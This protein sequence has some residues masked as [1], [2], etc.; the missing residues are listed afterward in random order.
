MV[1]TKKNISTQSAEMLGTFSPYCQYFKQV[2]D[3]LTCFVKP[4]G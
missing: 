3:F 4:S 2:G 1:V